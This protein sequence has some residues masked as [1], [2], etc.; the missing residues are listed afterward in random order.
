MRYRFGEFTLDSSTRRLLRGDAESHLSPKAFDLLLLLVSNSSRALAKADLV[1]HLWPSTYV[2]ETNLASL[3][4]EIRQALDD[5]A[6]EPRFVRTVHRFGY[7]FIGDVRT[8]GTPEPRTPA[9]RYWLFWE[10]RQIALSDGDNLVG[11]APDAAIW[12]DAPGVSRHHARIR[13]EGPQATIEDLDSKN[14]TFVNGRK[15]TAA[16]PLA[17]GDQ[18][19]LGSV[20]LTFRIPPPP[21]ATDTLPDAI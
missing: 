8:D 3:I 5:S 6:D 13:V 17:D 7:W 15:V 18:I 9:V 10:T 2:V 21:S 19:R 12:I 16:T 1:Q 11:R 20:V 4:A 14:G